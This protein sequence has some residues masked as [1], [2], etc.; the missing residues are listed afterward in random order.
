MAVGLL[1][2][3]AVV[4]VYWRRKV[5]EGVGGRELGE[6]KRCWCGGFE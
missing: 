1:R 6:V 2:R 5:V 3:K 4:V